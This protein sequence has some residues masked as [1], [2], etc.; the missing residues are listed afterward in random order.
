MLNHFDHEDSFR[1]ELK[2]LEQQGLKRVIRNPQ[3][4]KLINFSSNDY[5][6]FSHHPDVIRAASKTLLDERV[7][8]T[9]SRLLAGSTAAHQTL[10]K[11]LADFL[12]KE[13]ALVYSSGYHANTGILSTLAQGGD[14]IFV[15]ELCHASILDG[16][17]LSKA[18]FCTFDHN[19]PDHLEGLLRKRRPLYHRAFIVTEGIFSMDG[20]LGMLQE[21]SFL[22]QKWKALVYLDEAHSFGVLGPQG[23]GLAAQLGLLKKVD[24]FIGTLSKALG[25]QGGF[26]A[27]TK[28]IVDL[29]VSRSRS[30]IYTTALSPVCAAAA[31]AAL[32]ILPQCE[33]RT[34]SLLK[35]SERI[36]Q[37]LKKLGFNTLKS[38]AQ[39]IPVWTGDIQSTKNLSDYLLSFGFFVPSIRP[40]TVAKGEGRVRLSITHDV[41]QIGLKQLTHAFS[42]Y[43]LKT[44]NL[45]EKIGQTG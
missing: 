9:S 3:T 1:R 37:Y 45:G 39:I 24:I 5:L 7:G 42:S 2:D 44:K 27:T 35:A 16:I 29:L 11:N 8:G 10:E 4:N 22:A 18:R 43:S 30:F 36:R 41:V 28:E 33:D 31:N 12:S 20:D 14:V 13:A 23:K 38:Q 17:R 26:V 40:P 32:G 19:N 6:G 25:S 21:I 34:Q 15:D